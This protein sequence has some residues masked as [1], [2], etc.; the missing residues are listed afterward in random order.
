M[1][2]YKGKLQEKF[3][4]EAENKETKSKT[5]VTTLQFLEKDKNGK[6]IVVNIKDETNKFKDAEI[7]KE[8]Q[9]PITISFF[10]NILYYKV[11]LV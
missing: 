2:I 6:L 5:L 1:F 3:T 4:V 11:A 10:N 7:G 9:I 8:I